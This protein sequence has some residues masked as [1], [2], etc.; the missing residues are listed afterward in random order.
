VLSLLL[1]A[2]QRRD[3]VSLVTFRDDAAQVVLQP[4]GSV[5]VARARLVELPTGGRTP[6]AAGIRVAL[7]VATGAGRSGTYRPLLVL[8]TDGRATVATD[9]ADPVAAALA[10]AAEVR[11]KGVCGVVIDAEDG[12]IR[13]GLAGELA[14]AMG[15]RHLTVPE[16][17]AATLDAAVRML[18][19]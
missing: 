12:P 11:R 2:Y 18:S 7:E 1:D 3:K 4:T 15:A 13:L 14:D 10:A 17:S 8:I 19:Y 9:G 5:E 16:L 6:L